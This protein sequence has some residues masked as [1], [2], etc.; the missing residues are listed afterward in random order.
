[1]A[2]SDTHRLMHDLFNTRRISEIEPHLAPG[3]MFE[4]LPQGLTIKT[5]GEF[6]DYLNAWVAAF[7]D[8]NIG[9][10]TY[11]DGADFSVATFHGR[12]THDGQF[13][14]FAATGRT[15]DQPWCEILH[16]ASDGTILQGENYYDQVGLLRQL[17]LMPD[18]DAAM[19]DEGLEPAL[20]RLMTA[21]DAMDVDAATALMTS[22]AQGVDE[23]SR[24]W[25]RGHDAVLEY[26]RGLQDQVS[27]IRSEFRELNETIYGDTGIATFWIEQDYTMGGERQHV[28]A[29]TTMVFRREGGEWKAALVHSVPLPEAG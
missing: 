7:S 17:G 22:D 4:D 1:M 24:R 12:G 11:L 23:I 21:F 5:G 28:S 26:F 6:I 8:G 2:H 10:A 25:M 20:R 18:A 14:P 15:V 13:G 9:S 29:P 19:A 27:D 16:Y 3:F